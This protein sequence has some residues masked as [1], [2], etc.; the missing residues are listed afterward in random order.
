MSHFLPLKHLIILR[1]V[2][3]SA[4]LSAIEFAVWCSQFPAPQFPVPAFSTNKKLPAELVSFYL[5][6]TYP[7]GNHALTPLN[8]LGT[9]KSL[10]AYFTANRAGPELI[11]VTSLV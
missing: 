8:E 1:F 7:I 11:L 9:V 3:S 4:S 6:I 2:L 10:T 5:D